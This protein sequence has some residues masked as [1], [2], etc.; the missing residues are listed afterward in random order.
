MATHLFSEICDQ[1]EYIFQN[2]WMQSR[3]DTNSIATMENGTVRQPV[4]EESD[5][6][7][8]LM[9]QFDLIPYIDS[10]P[11]I[12]DNCIIESAPANGSV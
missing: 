11:T 7:G 5:I 2:H 9:D 8:D 12:T 1:N 6:L 10:E 3:I 4:Q